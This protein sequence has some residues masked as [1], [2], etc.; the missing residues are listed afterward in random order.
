[1][2]DFIASSRFGSWIAGGLLSLVLAYLLSKIPSL[3]AQWF[4]KEL[5]AVLE[6][7][8]PADDKLV[9]AFVTWAEAKL[10]APGSGP[11]KYKLVADKLVQLFPALGLDEAKLEALIEKTVERMEEEADKRK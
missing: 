3:L 10:P 7:G 2:F 5:D 1:M 9:M 8:D 11:E 4:G 6:A